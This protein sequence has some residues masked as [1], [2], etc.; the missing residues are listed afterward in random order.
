MSGVLLQIENLSKAFGGVQALDGVDLTLRKGEIHCLAGENGSGKSTLIKIVSGF[1][2]PDDGIIVFD[3]KKYGN[4]TVNE[5]IR[6]G[7]QVIYQDFS[8]FP[9]LTVAENIALNFELANR[10]KLVNWKK[11]REIA[12]K[13]L[14]R[15]GIKLPLD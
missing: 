12:S 15:I 14:E 3:G 9:N 6:L 7:I 2:K 4:M 8:I 11:V 10:K 1:Y 5:A 13:S